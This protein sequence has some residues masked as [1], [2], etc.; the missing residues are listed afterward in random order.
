MTSFLLGVGCGV[1]LGWLFIP[2]PQ[3]VADIYAK[4]SSK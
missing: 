2:M 3:W 1:L 4:L